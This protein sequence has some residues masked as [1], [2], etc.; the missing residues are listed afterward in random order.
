M[1]D[2]TTAVTPSLAATVAHCVPRQLNLIPVGKNKEALVRWKAYQGRMVTDAELSEWMT[3]GHQGQRVHSFGVVTGSVSGI[4]VVDS[5]SKDAELW[6]QEHLLPTP[7]MVKTA[8]GV[9]RYYRTDGPV[10]GRN[11]PGEPRVDVKGD[12]GY[13]VAPFSVHRTG[14]IY[15]P[16]GDWTV[17]KDDLPTYDPAWF[18]PLFPEPV[19]LT[20]P[21]V[22]ALQAALDHPPVDL[23]TRVRA[24]VAKCPP[25]VQGQGGDNATFVMCAQLVRD[26][27]LSD[28]DAFLALQ[29]WNARCIPPW[30]DKELRLKIRSARKSAR[31][32][33]GLKLLQ[34][35]TPTPMPTPTNPPRTPLTIA[36]APPIT[37]ESLTESGDAACFA[38]RYAGK[39]MFDKQTRRWHCLGDRSGLWLPDTANT[40]FQLAESTMVARRDAANAVSDAKAWGWAKQGLNYARLANLLR[41][42]ENQ[43]GMFDAGDTW[44][45]DNFL[46]GTPTG[47]I[48]LRTGALR[49]ALPDDRVTRS[50]TREYDP[51][52]TCPIWEATLREIFPLGTDRMIDW[53]QRAI[54][55][56]LT[57]ATTEE[58][59]FVLHGTGRNGKG[60]V[61][62]TLAHIFGDYADAL[63]ASS[64]Q[65]PA[66][67]PSSGAPTPDI[68]KLPGRRLVTASEFS[69][70]PLNEARLKRLSGRDPIAC[71]LKYQPE[72][73]FEPQFKLWLSMDKPPRVHEASD[74]FW[75]RMRLVPFTVSFAGREDF[76]LKDRLRTEAPGILAWVVRGAVE[77]GRRG[78]SVD[79]PAR[80]PRQARR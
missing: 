61:I 21:D 17:P 34:G 15:E 71:Q 31:H 14:V 38:S 72:F 67:Q 24:Y 12:G 35:R 50:V 51:A 54:G 46:V 80:L 10:S 7:W 4:V 43:P 69:R 79:M 19:T 64:L 58:V 9:H 8:R 70:A 53:L 57:G 27:A 65:S 22:A 25:A 30:T 20:E 42:A 41:L 26:F 28:A 33:A 18:A 16:V 56:S 49:S 37:A 1:S 55:Y 45:K 62:N 29:P 60:T 13:V 3:A 44:D 77:W 59:F 74:G 11:H 48:D 47:L 39:V 5:D 23:M 66:H 63:D 36:P 78:L 73:T 75:Q 6:C 40:V 2:P 68:A 52:A 76:T 32:P